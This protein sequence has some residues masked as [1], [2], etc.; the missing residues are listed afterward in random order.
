I[1]P[2]VYNEKYPPEFF[3][4]IVI[5]ECHRSIYNLWRQVIE[6]FDAFHIGLTATPDKRTFAFFHENVVSEYSHEQAVVDGVN[7]GYDTYVIETEITQQG[8]KINAKEFIDIRNKL[9]REER[10]EQLDEEFQYFGNDLDRSVVNPSQIR[11]IIKTFKDK[12]LTE[13]FPDRKEVPKTLIFAKSDSHADDII[14]I[15]REEFAE[16]NEFCKKITYKSLEDPKS[17]LA[18]FR[19]DY[20][21]RISVTVD[22]IATGTDVKPIECIIFMRDVKSKNY[23]EQMKGRGT[24]TLQKDDLR[25][26]T[27]SAV[28]NKTHYVIVDAVGVCK[29]LKT[30]SRPLERKPSIPLKDLMT[31]IAMGSR[32]EDILISTANRLTRIERAVTENEK[33]KFKEITSGTS[34]K[35]VVKALL[36]ANDQDFIQTKAR[37]KYKLEEKEILTKKQIEETQKE[38]LDK[39]CDIFNN[40]D[41]REYIE[42][43]RKKH[44]QIIDTVN[45]DTVINADWD[46]QTQNQAE[47]TIETFKEFL[48]K[49]KDEI[50]AL[51]IFY[52]QPQRIKEI[53]FKMIN[54]LYSILKSPP[55]SLTV[56]RLWGAYYQLTNHSVK[57]VSKKRM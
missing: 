13:I 31:N 21:P 33:E 50:T 55:Y 6:Y 47:N 15:V 36:N 24:R 2:L 19:N 23:F 16:S 35:E 5:D 48:K 20:Y 34:I 14:Q 8:S 30:D 53:T 46:K 51:K 12:L 44:E 40:P 25:K 9:T 1:R 29:S 22:M 39:A 38:F 7:V 26:V 54:D 4:F 45:I 32:E 18:S 17:I 57:G 11:N 3:D 56:E 10:W 49:N 42:N 52:S 43:V 28:D 27:P 37:E 41:I